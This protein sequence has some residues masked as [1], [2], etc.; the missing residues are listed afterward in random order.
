[1]TASSDPHVIFVGSG[2]NSLV[3]A[4]L[5]ATRGKR[6]LVLERNDRLGGCIRTEE[7]FP[8]Y[9]HEVMSSWYPLFVGS[10]G[11][12][13]LKPALEQAGLAF[14]CPDYTTGL[15]W[16]DGRGLALKQDL[17]DAVQRLEALA[18]GDGAALGAMAA[19]LFLSLIH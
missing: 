14:L 16:P 8:G 6:V 12:A 9:H 11:Y 2:I 1:M 10:P 15:V 3:S 7:L 13:E 18:P 4:A 5:L 19:R 17:N